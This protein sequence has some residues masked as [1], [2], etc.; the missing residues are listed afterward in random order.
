MKTLQ[1]IYGQTYVGYYLNALTEEREISGVCKNYHGTPVLVNEKGEWVPFEKLTEDSYPTPPFVE[2]RLRESVRRF[3]R[4]E[5]DKEKFL[6]KLESLS[7]DE[8]EELMTS[9]LSTVEADAENAE[10]NGEIVADEVANEIEA[11]VTGEE[12][13]EETT[14]EVTNDVKNSVTSSLDESSKRLD[15]ATLQDLVTLVQN[16]YDPSQKTPSSSKGIDM[17]QNLMKRC[18][19]DMNKWFAHFGP[20]DMPEE[21]KNKLIAYIEKKILPNLTGDQQLAIP[22]LKVLQK[23]IGA[24][25]TPQESAAALAKDTKRVYQKDQIAD[26]IFSEQWW[27]KRWE[28]R[29]QQLGGLGL[30]LSV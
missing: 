16:V 5:I 13:E 18:G 30:A 11:W 6:D 21:G 25:P 7:D 22:A 14:V 12:V 19:S 4:E 29:K 10:E 3:L 17:L 2:P 8:Q 26:A 20:L 24:G 1:P 9:L 15:E 23:Y 27:E 28:N